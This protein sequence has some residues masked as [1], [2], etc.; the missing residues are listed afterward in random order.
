MNQLTPALAIKSSSNKLYF[1]IINK[2]S[3]FFERRDDNSFGN[4]KPS[5]FN[6]GSEPNPIQTAQRWI[7]ERILGIKSIF[8]GSLLLDQ[9]ISWFILGAPSKCVGPISI[10]G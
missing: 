4:P 8:I 10:I 6:K 9:R 2:K 7:G 3:R 1:L 5:Y